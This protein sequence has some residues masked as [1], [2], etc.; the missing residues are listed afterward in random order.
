MEVF[1]GLG[2]ADEVHAAGARV[3]RVFARECLASPEQKE[4]LDPVSLLNTQALSPEPSFWYCPQSR[5]EPI[6]LAAARRRGADVR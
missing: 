3:S 2:L 5:L 1:R 6:L 4:L